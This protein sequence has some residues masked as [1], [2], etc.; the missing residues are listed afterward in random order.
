MNQVRRPSVSEWNLS[1]LCRRMFHVVGVLV[2][3]SVSV[4]AAGQTAPRC[5]LETSPVFT[6]VTP[7]ASGRRWT[8]RC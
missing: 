7:A 4:H 2:Q 5:G 1:A 6:C 3:S 8:G